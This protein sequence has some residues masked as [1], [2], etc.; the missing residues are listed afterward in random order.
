MGTTLLFFFA[1]WRNDFVFLK[2]RLLLVSFL[3]FLRLK[4]A[5]VLCGSIGDDIDSAKVLFGVVLVWCY[6]RVVVVVVLLSLSKIST[7]NKNKS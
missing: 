5:R 1:K 3:F 2:L 7:K 6:F 4:D